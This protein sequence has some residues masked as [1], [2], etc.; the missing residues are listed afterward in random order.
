M[1]LK[2]KHLLSG[3]FERAK[4]FHFKTLKIR[5]KFQGE[6]HPAIGASYNN[7]GLIYNEIGNPEQALAYFKKG[8]EVKIKSQAILKSVVYSM[9]NIANQLC[10][11]KK[12]HEAEAMLQDALNK[13][14]D[15]ANPSRDALSLTYD[16][17]GKVYLTQMKYAEADQV[18]EKAVEIRQEIMSNGIGFA[19]SLMHLAQAKFGS[20][21][22][23]SAR[24][25][26]ERVLEL[27]TRCTEDMPQ[28]T[29]IL[30]SL[31]LLGSIYCEQQNNDKRIEVLERQR[32]ELTRLLVF[33][34]TKK[35][36]SKL[37]EMQRKLDECIRLLN[38]LRCNF[39]D[40]NKA[41]MGLI[42]Q[43]RNTQ[44]NISGA[45]K[46]AEISKRHEVKKTTKHLYGKNDLSECQSV[47]S[48]VF[49]DSNKAQTPLIDQNRNTKP[50]ISGAAKTAAEISKQHEAS[51]IA[52]DLDDKNDLSS[53]CKN[54]VQIYDRANE[55]ETVKS[56]T[57]TPVPNSK[58]K[59]NDFFDNFCRHW[60]YNQNNVNSPKPT[61]TKVIN[62]IESTSDSSDANASFCTECG[63]DSFT[64][65][66]CI[67]PKQHNTNKENE[68]VEISCVTENTCIEPEQH[69]T[70][71]ESEGVENSCVIT[72]DKEFEETVTNIPD[73]TSLLEEEGGQT[74][75]D[76]ELFKIE[77]Y[78]RNNLD[79]DS[80]ETRRVCLCTHCLAGSE[81]CRNTS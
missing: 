9:N 19:E 66:T 38:V 34:D 27:Q 12:F 48:N 5:R 15:D 10:S 59:K 8:L 43:S 21:H 30:E 74:G 46:S 56:N 79:K 2:R 65:N 7:I 42:D 36:M 68:S 22:M 29:I 73:L 70:N 33:F 45:A 23:G 17:L 71:K 31:E 54:Q 11:L 3:N 18:L 75:A 16:T 78:C 25:F 67:D 44:S 60:N 69:N 58:A 49:P 26:I 6:Y 24:V 35:C 32:S 61:G 80:K 81:V 20:N 50:N 37:D 13:L 72:N 63:R 57:K 64:D 1:I 47:L 52:N 39:T 55:Y 14:Q 77:G 40:S 76:H 62:T 51:K 41:Q 53:Q 28:N 4:N